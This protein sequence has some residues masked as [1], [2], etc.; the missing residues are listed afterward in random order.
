MKGVESSINSMELKCIDL[1]MLHTPRSGLECR[2]EAYLRLPD[3]L[4]TGKVKTMGVSNWALR[5]IEGLMARPDVEVL[6]AVNQVKS[7]PL[8]PAEG[9]L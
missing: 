6:P 7:H 1:Y 8:E 4:K 5:H 3:M 2:V 9:D